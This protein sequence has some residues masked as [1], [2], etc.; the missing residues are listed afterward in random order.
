MDTPIRPGAND[1]HRLVG[2]IA[3]LAFV[4]L[5]VAGGVAQGDVPVYSEGPTV[6]KD[7][8]ANNGDRWLIAG[9]LLVLAMIFYVAFLAALVT[10]LLS[11]DDGRSPWPLLALLA[12]VHLVVAVQASVAFD[13]TLALLKGEVSNDVARTLSAGDY[14]TFLL[15][16]PFAGIQA[17]AVSLCIFKTGVLSRALAWFGPIVAAGGLVA[18]AAP[19]EHDPEGVLTVVGYITLF[20]FLAFAAGVSL[21]MIRTAR[22][23]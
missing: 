1:N 8:F 5:V 16:Y 15:V 4:A 19:L 2:G 10:S 12:G 14:M 20:A 9:C 21:S 23:E 13:G 7:W 3:G 6:I 18:A 22:R 17:L 11:A